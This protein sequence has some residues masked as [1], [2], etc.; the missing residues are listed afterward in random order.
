MNKQE[1]SLTIK[2]IKLSIDD[3]YSQENIN[4]FI[5]GYIHGLNLKNVDWDIKKV[6]K[7]ICSQNRDLMIEY[8][9][10]Q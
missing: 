7:N 2:N 9:N 6:E 4:N 1:F 10:K 5:E 3:S 8:L